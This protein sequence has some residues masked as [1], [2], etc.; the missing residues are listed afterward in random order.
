[1]GGLAIWLT[2][3]PIWIAYDIFTGQLAAH[4]CLMIGTAALITVSWIDD[5]KSLPARERFMVH[6]LAVALGLISLPID[7]FVFQGVLPLWLDRVVAGFAWIWFINLTNFMDGIDG[8]SGAQSIHTSLAFIIIAAIL[9]SMLQH[10]II[11]E[12]I[13]GASIGF[14][15]WNWHPAKLFMGDVGSIPLGYLLGF[16]MMML[17]INGYLGVAITIPLYYVADASL[18]LIRRMIE[19]KKF[20]QAHR[21]HFYQQAALGAKSPIP[22]VKAIIAANIGLLLISVGALTVS[23]WLLLFAPLLISGLLWYLKGLRKVAKVS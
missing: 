17:A 13:F 11:A 12:C 16:L 18:T 7:H 3:F 23:V 6:V 15:I 5:K 9:G 19:K 10:T 8:I 1:G 22:V 21:E 4:L 20:W 2:V 14:L